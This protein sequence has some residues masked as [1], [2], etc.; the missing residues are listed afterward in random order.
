MVMR[1]GWRGAAAFVI[2]CCSV[3]GCGGDDG[4]ERTTTVPRTE[5]A[6][7]QLEA[8]RAEATEF[9]DLYYG[10]WPDISNGTD[11]FAD[12]V[13][14]S[15][16]GDGDHI[17]GKQSVASALAQWSSYIASAERTSG[18]AFVSGDG[19]AHVFEFGTPVWPPWLFEPDEHPDVVEIEEFRFSDG[20]TTEFVVWLRDDTLEMLDFGCFAVDACPDY[21]EVVDRYLAAWTSGDAEVVAALYAEDAVFTDGLFGWEA[22][23]PG[24]I[25]AL[26]E[27][28]FGPVDDFAVEVIALYGQTNGHREPSE[29]RPDDGQVYG[30]AIHYRWTVLD[31]EGHAVESLTTFELGSR[32]MSGWSLHPDGLITEENVF[33][34]VD[35]LLAAG[36]T[37]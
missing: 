34:D 30:V 35:T 20:L 21:T 9:V 2:V 27:R 1:R 10:A 14:F 19:A 29:G 8:W 6:A 25:G 15:A 32:E 26:A 4:S 31:G 37:A 24:D 5:L 3:E 28:R 12:D 22:N 16:P 23:G 13:V 36:L 18:D 33:H 7:D 17:E 11:R